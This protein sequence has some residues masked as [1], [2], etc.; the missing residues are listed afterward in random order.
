MGSI[1]LHNFRKFSV[2]EDNPHRVT[3]RQMSVTPEGPSLVKAL[4]Q[5]AFGIISWALQNV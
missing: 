2:A 3:L 5:K 1:M 4:W